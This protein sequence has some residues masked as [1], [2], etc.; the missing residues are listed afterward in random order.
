MVK[1]DADIPTRIGRG[2]M[3]VLGERSS[4]HVAD[5]L[6]SC[7]KAGKFNSVVHSFLLLWGPQRLVGIAEDAERAARAIQGRKC[8][9]SCMFHMSCVGTQLVSV[10]EDRNTAIISSDLRNR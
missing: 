1:E 10:N 2:L 9:F 3:H 4:K 5:G 8:M 7:G 6:E